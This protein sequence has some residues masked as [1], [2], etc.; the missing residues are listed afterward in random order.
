M[1]TPANHE[2]DRP[3]ELFRFEKYARRKATLCCVHLKGKAPVQ[4]QANQGK[5]PQV[6]PPRARRRAPV[7]MED[8]DLETVGLV[9]EGTRLYFFGGVLLAASAASPVLIKARLQC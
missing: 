6:E 5:A 7:D 1:H 2:F 4:A 8:P 3:E 9:L